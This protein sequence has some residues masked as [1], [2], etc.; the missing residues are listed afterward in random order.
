MDKVVTKVFSNAVLFFGILLILPNFGCSGLRSVESRLIKVD[1]EMYPWYA[2]TRDLT[3]EVFERKI[4]SGQT[5]TITVIDNGQVGKISRYIKSLRPTDK[6]ILNI[7][8]KLTLHYEDGQVEEMFIG[9]M[10]TIDYRDRMFVGAVRLTGL[11][12]AGDPP[13]IRC[14]YSEFYDWVEE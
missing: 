6:E 2:R 14:Q 1:A 5:R 9:R 7:R 11:I 12:V 4:T 13:H 3:K 8:M 10:G